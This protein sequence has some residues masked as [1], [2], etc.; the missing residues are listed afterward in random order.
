MGRVRT[1]ARRTFLIGSA[2]IAGGV[3]FGIYTVRQ[4]LDNP[5]ADGLADGSVTFN[6]WVRISADGIT[7]ITPHVDIG[8]GSVHMQAILIAEELDLDPGGYTTSFGPPDGAYYNRALSDEAGEAMSQIMPLSASVMSGA[9]GVAFKMLG[10]QITGGSSSVP[11]SYDKLREAGAVARETLKLAASKQSNVPVA[12]LTTRSGKVILPD[13][14]EIAYTDLA[15]LAA[16][17][18]PVRDV[19]LRPPS[20]WRLIGTPTLRADIVAKSTGTQVFGI[21]LQIDGMVHAAVRVNPHRT[22]MN[23]YDA[24]QADTMPGVQRILPVTNGVAV[25]ADS[26]WNA[27]SAANAL[28]FDWAPAQYP[29]EQADHWAALAAGFSDDQLNAEWRNDGDVVTALAGSTDV[30]DVEYRAPYVAHQ[31][32]EPLSALALVTD[33]GVTLWAGHQVPRFVQQI[34]AEITGHTPEQVTLH[35]QYC[36]GSFGHRLEFENIRLVTEIANQMRGTPVKLTFTREEDFAQDFPRHIAMARCRGRVADGQVTDLD[37]SVAAA[38]VTA[39]QGSR[40]GL[41]PS[42]PDSQL[43]AGIWNAPYGGLQGF[44]V[45]DYAVPG[46]APVSSWR[47]VG[48]SYGGF[49]IETALDELIHAAGADPVAE[50][51]RLITD[52][53]AR[54]V[55][56]AA[57]EMADWG[58]DPGPD[59]GRGVA[60]VTSF[61]VPVAEIVEV[62]NTPNGIRIDKVWVVA[63]PGPIIDPVNCENN[64]QGGV[65]WGLGHAMNSEITYDDGQP[66]QS[67]YHAAE[68][69]RLHQSPQIMVKTLS[70][71]PHIRG[72]GEPPVPPAA[73]ALANA[74]FAATGQRLREMPFHKF[75]DFV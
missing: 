27:F 2:A 16:T 15:A 12:D 67:N 28:T 69:M 62:T 14:S 64:I 31:P 24:A 52:P 63:D 19:A 58:S 51:L 33:D 72:I 65:V 8:Q 56:E 20:Q 39:S 61:G 34:A 22:P 75:I 1:I 21:D 66:E 55:L 70:N 13:G 35:G 30:I 44:R 32:L 60:L 7:L 38:P 25:I 29:A 40:L 53:V 5:L 45:R 48:A 37:I 68:G 71:N 11:D 18:D 43:S 57:A 17:L 42:G 36:G 59:K 26:T 46:L 41:P 73:P 23:S 49:F 6:P 74:I 50:R 3:A 10:M 47:A 4:P 9:M 54:A